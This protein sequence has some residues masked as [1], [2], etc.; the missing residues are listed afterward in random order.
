MRTRTLSTTKSL[1]PCAL[2][3]CSA[4]QAIADNGL[5]VY[6][7]LNAGAYYLDE[8]DITIESYE[9]GSPQFFNRDTMM[10][11]Q[12]SK[13]I[14]ERTSATIQ[15]TAKGE[16]DF[17]V[18]T[19]LA[20]IS[21]ALND[22]TDIRFGRLR[23]PF[24]YYSE[25]LDVGYAYNWIRPTGDAYGIPFSDY[26]GAD[27]IKRFSFDS[28]D[29][30]IQLNYGRRD[31]EIVLF[32]EAYES[33]LNNFAGATLNLY[34]GDFGLRVG[35]QQ[36]QMTLDSAADM[37]TL[38]DVR[39]GTKTPDE[40]LYDLAASGARRIDI[41]QTAATLL[42]NSMSEETKE[43]FNFD[44]KKARYY[45]L[46]TTWDNGDWS[47]I[48]ETAIINFDSGLYVDNFAWLASLAKRFDALT[49]HTTYS[50]SRDRLDGGDVGKV[51]EMMMLRGE[52]ESITLGMRYDLDE[53]TA[54][55]LEASHHIEETNQGLPGAS[56]TLY[57]A[58]LQLVF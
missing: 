43:T 23:I 16:E 17:A 13:E 46:A 2:L 14:S 9:S 26:N 29:G 34:M 53:A 37:Q 57:R 15:L 52:D 33:E 35:M 58:A 48:A 19:S 28:F 27:I 32:N 39:T 6:G 21:H 22:S 42:T 47:F 8:D 20:F 51:Q 54:F 5:N 36:T 50:T 1:L 49:I 30:Q 12:I 45:N 18:R 7:F 44:D 4:G 55:K 40:A 41:A 11:L 3:L 56:G 38:I 10:G 25:F 31:K 24:F